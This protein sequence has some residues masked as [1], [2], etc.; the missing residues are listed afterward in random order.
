M[1]ESAVITLAHVFE[2]EVGLHAVLCGPS[3][4]AVSVLSAPC[5]YAGNHRAP[6]NGQAERAGLPSRSLSATRKKRGRS[7]PLV[8]L[9]PPVALQ[10]LLGASVMGCLCRYPFIKALDQQRGRGQQGAKSPLL[11]DSGQAERLLAG[12]PVVADIDARLAVRGGG[13]AGCHADSALLWLGVKAA[14][15][16]RASA[17]SG[18]SWTL[19]GSWR[20]SLFR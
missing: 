6:D 14:P 15:L 12:S 16:C 20:V 13:G 17:R 7:S 3:L 5:V 11:W 10:G 8:R 1:P 18:L 9:A 4:V 2:D 19:C